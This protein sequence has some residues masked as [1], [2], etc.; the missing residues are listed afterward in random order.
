MYTNGGC[1]KIGYFSNNNKKKNVKYQIIE[2]DT[3]IIF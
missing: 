2:C 3:I 1:D